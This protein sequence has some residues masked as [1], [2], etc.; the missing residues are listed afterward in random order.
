LKG[1]GY[2]DIL[3]RYT[4]ATG[5]GHIFPELSRNA[6]EEAYSQITSEARNQYTLGYNPKAIGGSS[7]YRNIEVLVHRR[8]LDVYTKAGYYPI[9]TAK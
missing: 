5:G 2:F 6:I 1:Q 3:P 4:N 8:E 9:P 7:A